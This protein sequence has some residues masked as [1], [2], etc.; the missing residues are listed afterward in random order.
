M[1]KYMADEVRT[2]NTEK[3]YQVHHLKS[4]PKTDSDF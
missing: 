1:V 2:N 3:D 4:Q